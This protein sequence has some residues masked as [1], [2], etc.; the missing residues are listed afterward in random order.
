MVQRHDNHYQAAQQVD[1]FD[2]VGRLLFWVEPLPPE[3]R[4]AQA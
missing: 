2:T 1:G 4:Q 3:Y